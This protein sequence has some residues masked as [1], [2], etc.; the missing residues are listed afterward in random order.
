MLKRGLLFLFLVLFQKNFAVEILPREVITED[1]ASPRDFGIYSQNAKINMLLP[2][3]SFMRGISLVKIAKDF[4]RQ[5]DFLINFDLLP[6]SEFKNELRRQYY[7]S[8]GGKLLDKSP[9]AFSVLEL[10]NSGFLN[11]KILGANKNGILDLSSLR[12]SSLEGL[13]DLLD[14]IDIPIKSLDL[15]NNEINFIGVADFSSYFARLEKLNLS[16]NSIYEIQPGSFDCLLN[17]RF[18]DLGQNNITN[19]PDFIFSMC[20]KLAK[21]DLSDNSLRRVSRKV[22]F[23]LKDCLEF[24]NLADNPIKKLPNN[25]FAGFDNLISVYL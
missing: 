17:I 11:Y 1:I 3:I 18:I 12:I 2:S 20:S 25:F 16:N 21:I 5:D 4:V 13:S 22:F 14:K 23:G 6:E 10:L 8:S 19:L 9:I 24:L 15:S 7:F